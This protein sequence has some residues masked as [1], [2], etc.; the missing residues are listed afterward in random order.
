MSNRFSAR[1]E[2]PCIL[3][4]WKVHYHIHKKPPPVPIQTQINTAY[5]PSYFLKIHFSITLQSTLPSSKWSPFLR[6]LPKPCKHLFSLPY[7]LHAP[8]ISFFLKRSTEYQTQSTCHEAPHYVVFSNHPLQRP[9]IPQS[10]FCCI[11]SNTL[12]L[13]SSL[14]ISDQSSH[15]HQTTLD[16]Q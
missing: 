16:I 3:W 9:S 6:S 10:I 8:P 12:S 13:R 11:S 15:S 1:Q 4:N 14:Y 7:V 5:S 2:I